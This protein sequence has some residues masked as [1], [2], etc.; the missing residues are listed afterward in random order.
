M[1]SHSAEGTP[2]R[3]VVVGASMA[4]AS[5]VEALRRAG[6]SGALTLMGAEPHLPYERPPLSK[7]VLTGAVT[8]ESAFLRDAGFYAEHEVHLRLGTRAT[9]LDVPG[10]SVILE[11]GERI[12][13][14]R[15]LI[16]TGGEPRQLR[17]PG[18]DLPGVRYLRTLD[19]ARV[20][21]TDL[22]QLATISSRLV[23]VGAGFIG[24]EVA[25]SART[26]GVAVTMLE[27]L[28]LP[29]DRV[30][31]PR[32][33]AIYADIHRAHGVDLRL[34]ESIAEIRG[35]EQVEAVVTERGET[36]ACGL[37]LVGIGMRPAD[38]WLL[39]SGVALGDGVL[40]DEYCEA[41]IPGIFAAGDVARWPLG[42]D[43]ERVRLEHYDN[44]LRQGEAAA[45]NMLGQRQPYAP[46]PYF[47]SDQYDLKL[48][49]V[50]HTAGW[51]DVVLRG[52]PASGSFM[53]FFLVAGE[54]LAA[55]AV[56]RT[57]D[58]MALRKLVA[59]RKP[60]DAALL[61]SD[62]MPIISLLPT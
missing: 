11:G 15:L 33:G 36:I 37:V 7:G 12:S 57:R 45:R 49:M 9:A 26:L 55:V 4:G 41:N 17:V 59:A 50:G 13:F 20:L 43:G 2:Q 48:Q 46:V 28:P 5:T 47:W 31:G 23:V 29:L 52:D 14:D 61:S 10:R 44:A 6:Y 30:L 18:A 39:D 51:D 38:D 35:R 40:V 16:A 53:A 34:G 19:D 32:L 22:R 42:S 58:L 56:N 54:P 24:S 60:I 62:D 25:A 3:I 27:V 21:A 8:P 1:Q